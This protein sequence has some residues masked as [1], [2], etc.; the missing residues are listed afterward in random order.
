MKKTLISAAL[1]IAI[2]FFPVVSFA[3]NTQSQRTYSNPGS[4]D[5]GT[6]SDGTGNTTN[7]TS[8]SG[9]NPLWLLPLL[10][11]PVLF[12][13]MKSGSYDNERHYDQQGFTGAK[14]G[15][16]RLTRDSV[17]EEVL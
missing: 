11:I 6:R 16:S 2:S 7:T 4:T 13:A 10:A 3:Q 9:F 15:R 14:G 1:F 17:D 5:M 12:I 8:D